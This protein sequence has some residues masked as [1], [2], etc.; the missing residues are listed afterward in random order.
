MPIKKFGAGTQTWILDRLTSFEAGL[1][2]YVAHTAGGGTATRTN[3][4]SKT[5][6]WSLRTNAPAIADQAYF[7]KACDGPGS[8]VVRWLL[9]VYITTYNG[10]AA[11]SGQVAN[12]YSVADGCYV[13]GWYLYWNKVVG[14]HNGTSVTL[15]ASGL[16]TGVWHELIIDYDFDLKKTTFYVDGVVYGPYI[17]VTSYAMNTIYLGDVAVSSFQ[18]DFYWDTDYLGPLLTIPVT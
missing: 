10:V 7:T 5:G 12:I 2:N 6:L 16:S 14:V 8:G 4:K 9:H 1:Q 3:A 18:G 13:I 15:I 11:T 17:D